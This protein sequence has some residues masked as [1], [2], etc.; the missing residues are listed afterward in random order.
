MAG[1][2]VESQWPATSW[3][4]PT[5]SPLGQHN[6]E[7]EGDGEAVETSHTWLAGTPVSF[8]YVILFSQGTV[9]QLN[10]VIIVEDGHFWF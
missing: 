4:R 8:V 7:N 3:G 2:D 10:C 1:I 6:G 9:K 5:W